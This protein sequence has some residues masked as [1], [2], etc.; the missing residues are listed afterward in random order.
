MMMTNITPFP[1]TGHSLLDEY[2]DYRWDEL[3]RRKVRERLRGLP[4]IMLRAVPTC[5][6]WRYDFTTGTYRFRL[7]PRWVVWPE[8]IQDFGQV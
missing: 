6:L 5:T 3:R 4:R 8:D 1:W 2:M 7:W